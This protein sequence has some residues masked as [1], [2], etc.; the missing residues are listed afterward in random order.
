M[1][2]GRLERMV[3]TIKHA[4]KE[5]RVKSGEDWARVLQKVLNCYC[6]RDCGLIPPSFRMMCDMTRGCQQATQWRS[7]PAQTISTG[8]SKCSTSRACALM[9]PHTQGKEGRVRGR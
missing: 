8:K 1:A 7:S 9:P 2:T 5:S 6:R 4:T 3:G